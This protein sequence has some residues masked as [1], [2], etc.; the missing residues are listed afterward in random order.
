MLRP[1]LARRFCTSAMVGQCLLGDIELAFKAKAKS[2]RDLRVVLV[3]LRNV[4]EKG[5]KA[6]SQWN[7]LGEGCDLCR[8]NRRIVGILDK[9]L[10]FGASNRAKN[11]VGRALERD[12]VDHTA[13]A[14]DI[15]DLE[16]SDSRVGRL[17]FIGMASGAVRRLAVY[18]RRWNFDRSL[19]IDIYISH[20]FPH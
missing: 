7:E 17:G 2:F 10:L 6:I 18:I 3:W 1:A 20:V 9:D 12:L 16:T 19:L 15:A 4:S 5:L 13:C 14:I 11:D 8:G